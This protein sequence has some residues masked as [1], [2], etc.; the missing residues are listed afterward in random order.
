MLAASLAVAGCGGA[1]PAARVDRLTAAVDEANRRAESA[2]E[3]A[4]RLARQLEATRKE[5]ADARHDAAADLRRLGR[6]VV[7][8]EGELRALVDAGRAD[9]EAADRLSPVGTWACKATPHRFQF[10]ADGRGRYQTWE[11]ALGRWR[12]GSRTVGT[13]ALSSGDFA[14]EPAGADGAYV[15]HYT[16]QRK[17]TAARVEASAAAPNASAP[18]KGPPAFEVA[19]ETCVVELLFVMRSSDDARLVGW[20]D[21]PVVS[22]VDDGWTPAS[23]GR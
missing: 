15:L 21:D 22:R 20:S 8:V 16:E 17:R 11:A 7:A 12:D 5:L 19:D 23:S 4:G 14:Y 13:M 1:E 3:E 2:A 9:R 6:H 18:S 10:F